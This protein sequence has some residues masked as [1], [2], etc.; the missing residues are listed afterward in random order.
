M[1]S[2]TRDDLEKQPNK[3]NNVAN[4]DTEIFSIWFQSLFYQ[5][6]GILAFI[7]LCF[8]EKNF[9]AGTLIFYY[10]LWAQSVFKKSLDYDI[11]SCF[12]CS[13]NLP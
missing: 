9:P 3:D 10:L 11:F 5:V 8:I 12:L 4:G 13:T 7:I 1:Q 6:E 2:D